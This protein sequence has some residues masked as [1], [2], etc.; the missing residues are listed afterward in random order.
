MKQCP[1]FAGKLR[2]I[3]LFLLFFG[4]TAAQIPAGVDGPAGDAAGDHLILFHFNDLHGRIERLSRMATV[5]R[6]ARR[7]TENVYFFCAGD[8]FSGNPAV[9]QADPRGEPVLKLLN[10]VGLQAMALGNHEFDYGQ[11]TLRAFIRRARF[12][13][14]CANVDAPGEALAGLKSHV[15]LGQKQGPFITLLGLVQVEPDSGI[16]SAHPSRLEGLV[17]HDSLKITGRLGKVFNNGGVRVVLSHLGYASDRLLAEALPGIDVIVGGHSHTVLDAGVEHNGVLIVQAGAH[18]DYLGRVD[19][20]LRGGKVEKRTARLIRLDRVPPAADILAMVRKF[21]DNPVLKRSIARLPRPLEGKTRLGNWICD[22][23]RGYLDLDVTF[24]NSGGVRVNRLEGD[25]TLKDVYKMLPFANVIVRMDLYPREIRN[26][27]AT[28]VAKHGKI[29]LLMSGI[30]LKISRTAD[31]NVRTVD[32]LDANGKPFCENRRY[33][34]G[35]NSYIASSYRF[36]REDPGKSMEITTAAAVIAYLESDAAVVPADPGPRAE[37]EI[38][39]DDPGSVVARSEDA[40][41]TGKNPYGSSTPAGNLMADAMRA[42]S[43]SEVAVFPSRLLVPGIRIAAGSP[44]GVPQ[45]KAM[46]RHVSRNRVKVAR[47]SGAALQAFLLARA[48]YR[49]GV[50]VQLSGLGCRIYRRDGATID[51]VECLRPDG[52]PLP[53]EMQLR[54][55]FCDYDFDRYY[56]LDVPVAES[57]GESD[58]L[59]AML[60]RFLKSHPRLDS[61]IGSPRVVILESGEGE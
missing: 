12:P 29:D 2:G 54:V 25:I 24:Q 3:F 19:L 37:E 43:G 42:G 1:G 48:R 4:I 30:H 47:M 56:K 36:D 59:E 46:Y 49:K 38:V 33:A 44:I 15:R 10:E 26:L 5:I 18:G 35:M 57:P 20:F 28:D 11:E 34:V 51:R 16:P 7:E 40:M 8:N 41:E 14:L 27:I 60:L 55:A 21:E 53:P 13:I 9:D 52:T 50:D 6:A 39:G 31:G 32:L 23:L 45:I 22:L 58:S 61:D 17:F